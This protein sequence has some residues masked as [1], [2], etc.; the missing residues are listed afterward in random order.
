MVVTDIAPQRESGLMDRLEYR[1]IVVV[2]YR[3]E[4][5][6]LY[7]LH[8]D[9]ISTTLGNVVLRI[10]QIGSTAV[11]GLAATPIVDLLVVVEH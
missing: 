8:D 10:E 7:R 9:R 6:D 5:P 2:S 11:P 3:P 4:W 1:D